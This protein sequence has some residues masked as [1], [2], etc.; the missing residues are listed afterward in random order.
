MKLGHRT[1]VVAS[2]VLAVS[3]VCFAGKEFSMPKAKPAASYP[4]HEYH[5]NEKV[6]VA[7]DPYDSPAKTSIFVVSYRDLELLPVFLVVTNDGDAPVALT[8]IKAQ[9]VTGD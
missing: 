8:D 3:L 9:F 7:V 6:T 1:I 2:S 5:S 4:A